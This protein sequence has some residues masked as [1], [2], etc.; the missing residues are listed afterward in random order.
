MSDTQLALILDTGRARRTDPRTSVDAAS[1]VCVTRRCAEL[2]PYL[3]RADQPVTAHELAM[4]MLRD[5]LAWPMA[6]VVAR[7][8]TDLERVDLARR[9][10]TV[11]GRFGA[12]C[13]TW[14]AVA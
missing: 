5:G 12:S 2:L 11:T 3:R 6:N 7:R 14:E 9:V 4:V 1:G 10:G 8:L 13:T